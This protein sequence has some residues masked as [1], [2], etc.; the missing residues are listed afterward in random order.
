MKTNILQKTDP[1]AP[2]R[3]NPT[4]RSIRHYLVV[5]IIGTDI[6]SGT[7]IRAYGGPGPPANSGISLL[8][9]RDYF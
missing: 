2:S 7:T 3:A 6:S 4:L 1:D 8:V 5:N 9:N